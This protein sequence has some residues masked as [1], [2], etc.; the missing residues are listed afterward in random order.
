[1][2]KRFAL[3]GHPLGHSLS[4]EIHAAIMA[5]T[6]LDG[7][8]ERLDVAPADVASRMPAL[9]SDYDGFNATIPHKKAVIPHLSGLSEAA[10]RCGAVNTVFEGR[11]YNTDA[12][13]FRAA[14]MPLAGGRVLL[15]E[16]GAAE[17]GL[18]PLS[19][20]RQRGIRRAL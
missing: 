9:L 17:K 8:Y 13:G 2:K 7:S 6:G 5:A 14:G 1:M 4:P 15:H 11:G 20:S 18:L 10:R 12:A 3:I 19:G 16:R